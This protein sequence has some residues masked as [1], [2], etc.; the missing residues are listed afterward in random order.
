MHASQYSVPVRFNESSATVTF[1]LLAS[2]SFSRK[3]IF[4]SYFH[5]RQVGIKHRM[6]YIYFRE[7]CCVF[8][9]HRLCHRARYI[10]I[11]RRNIY[12]QILLHDENIK[13]SAGSCI[14]IYVNLLSSCIRKQRW[15]FLYF[16]LLPAVHFTFMKSHTRL[17]P[18]MTSAEPQHPSLLASN[19]CMCTRDFLHDPGFATF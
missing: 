9:K 17:A 3:Y 16:F 7:I 10:L 12:V 2:S 6:K 8:L 5:K 15:H 1:L 18:V 11:H 4:P 14:G 13:S 19:V